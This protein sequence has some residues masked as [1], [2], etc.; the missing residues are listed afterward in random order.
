M[1]GVSVNVV[2]GF[3]RSLL[4]FLAR[5]CWG[6]GCLDILRMVL[7]PGVMYYMWNGSD[8]IVVLGFCLLC[9]GRV[10]CQ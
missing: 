8:S 1:W 2:R 6:G 7:V 5:S 10:S 9:V 4:G 3:I